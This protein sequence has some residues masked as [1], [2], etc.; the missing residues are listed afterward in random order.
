MDCFIHIPKC[1]GTSV[2]QVCSTITD[3]IKLPHGYSYDLGDNFPSPLYKPIWGKIH[4]KSFN[5]SNFDKIYTI[6]RNPFDLLV[7][8]YHHTHKESKGIDG[9]GNC[10]LVHGFKSWREFLDSYLNPYL[11]WHLQPMKKSLFSMAYR[12]NGSWIPD[13]TFY[14]ENLEELE[15]YF[16]LEFPKKNKTLNKTQ[17]YS[18]FYTPQDVYLLNKIWEDDLTKFNYSF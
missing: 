1:A 3:L 8:Y 11:P 16:G 18:K 14:F 17:H 4:K 13:K 2:E 6:V 15:E 5:P 9:W 12:N 7:S 10:N